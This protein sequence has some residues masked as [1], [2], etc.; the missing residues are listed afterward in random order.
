MLEFMAWLFQ[1][2]YLTKTPFQ[3]VANR[4]DGRFADQYS[5]ALTTTVTK[6][7]KNNFTHI[8]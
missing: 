2:V 8:P 6:I 5:P 7:T 4:I 1:V 3:C